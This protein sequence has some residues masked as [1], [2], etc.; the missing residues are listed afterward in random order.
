MINRKYKKTIKVTFRDIDVD[1]DYI[2]CAYHCI[3]ISTTKLSFIHFYSKRYSRFR[4]LFVSC[5][6]YNSIRF[7]SILYFIHF[8]IHILSSIRVFIIF[9]LL[10]FALFIAVFTS[11]SCNEKKPENI[12]MFFGIPR[13]KNIKSSKK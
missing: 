4:F 3:Y 2:L 1:V 6:R 11:T 8:F 12:I 5:V 9:M 10:S 13:S 7:Y